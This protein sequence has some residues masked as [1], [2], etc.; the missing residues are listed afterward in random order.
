[1]LNKVVKS[2]RQHFKEIE[3]ANFE[4]LKE[5]LREYEEKAE[6]LTGDAIQV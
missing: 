2:S 3:K 6:K 5:Q 4:M 1:V